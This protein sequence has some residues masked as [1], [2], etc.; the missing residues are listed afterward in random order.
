MQ[1]SLASRLDEAGLLWCH[2]PNEGKCS[3]REG[4]RRKSRGVKAGVPDILIF[5]APPQLH[6]MFVG[7]AIEL[8]TQTGTVS[9]EQSVWLARL[10]AAG[11]ATAV[12]RSEDE[13]VAQLR[14]WGYRV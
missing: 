3:A 12:C 4:G 10:A 11:W 13:A 8:K 1:I 2:V 6:S 7:A 14:A 9:P 5:D